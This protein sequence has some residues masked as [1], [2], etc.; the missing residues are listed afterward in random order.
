MAFWV[1]EAHLSRWGAPVEVQGGGR[2]PQQGF[3]GSD[4]RGAAGAAVGGAGDGSMDGGHDL[5][6]LR[7]DVPREP[8]TWH[9]YWSTTILFIVP[10]NLES[11]ISAS[12]FSG[13]AF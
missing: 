2:L 9:R 13:L 4:L 10:L 7:R 6:L 12:L 11:W 5:G 8:F 1:S 3:Q